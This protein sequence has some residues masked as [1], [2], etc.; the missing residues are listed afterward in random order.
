M[1]KRYKILIKDATGRVWARGDTL[2]AVEH[3]CYRGRE[4]WWLDEETGG[5]YPDSVESDWLKRPAP[6]HNGGDYRQPCYFRSQWIV[7]RRDGQTLGWG[8]TLD[9]VRG[10]ALSGTRRAVW[11]WVEGEYVRHPLKKE[12]RHVVHNN[13]PYLR[14]VE[15]RD[16]WLVTAASGRVWARGARVEDVIEAQAAGNKRALWQLVGEEY[17][18]R[19]VG[20]VW[21]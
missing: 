9:D 14:P 13:Y 5:Y 18:L 2:D 4:M 8:D 21:L 1:R 20:S 3:A 16:A 7:T 12:A 17:V 10:I 15:C 6:S 11:E 19:A